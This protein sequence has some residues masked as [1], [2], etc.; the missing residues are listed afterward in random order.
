MQNALFAFAGDV[1]QYGRIVQLS[2]KPQLDMNSAPTAP[3]YALLEG[4]LAKPTLPT[5][6]MGVFFVYPTVLFN[7]TDWIMDTKD[8]DMRA[9]AKTNVDTQAIDFLHGK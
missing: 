1:F 4:W 3:D 9:A 7:D 5:A 2:C 6:S 8:G